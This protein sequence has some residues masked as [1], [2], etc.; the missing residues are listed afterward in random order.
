MG[1]GEGMVI[2][3]IFDT[4]VMCYEVTVGVEKGLFATNQDNRET[5]EGWRR[6]VVV[7]CPHDV[8]VWV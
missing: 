3:G 2:V 5:T 1:G 6:D 8:P 4:D 7:R